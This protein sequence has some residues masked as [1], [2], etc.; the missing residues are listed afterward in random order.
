MPNSWNDFITGVVNGS[1][2]DLALQQPATKTARQRQQQVKQAAIDKVR[3]TLKRAQALNTDIDK[4]NQ[5]RDAAK[6]AAVKLGF[7]DGASLQGGAPPPGGGMP[8]GGGGMPPDPSMMGGGAPPDPSMMG[9]GGMPP[10][11]S[12][13]GGMPPDPSM[14]GG[15]PPDPSM[16][17]GGGA[18]PPPDAG[19]MGL[20]KDDVQKMIDDAVSS[21]VTGQP[22]S[23]M[24]P[25]AP[26]KG[27][28]AQQQML[29]KILRLTEL[30]N[31]LY[32]TMGLP[33]PLSVIDDQANTE[34]VLQQNGMNPDGS[35]D[36][37][38]SMSSQKNGT[39]PNNPMIREIPPMGKHGSGEKKSAA[40]R[41]QLKTSESRSA[42]LLQMLTRHANRID[43]K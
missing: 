27:K 31:G 36:S 17:M 4:L 8:P 12:M 15:M 32:N 13:M 2:P 22:P 42:A 30:I 25:A 1:A 7:I 9:G 21:A 20:T 11:P 10:D 6:W 39:I 5:R 18:P 41:N 3:N 35:G 29:N 37:S 19:G 33:I 34:A 40:L 14:M 28:D 23:S 38:S 26:T 43:N 24:N 16:M